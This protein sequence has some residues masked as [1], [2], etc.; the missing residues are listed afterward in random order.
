[1][2][3]AYVL[4]VS[5]HAI[6]LIL[7]ITLPILGV[8]LAVGLAVSIFQAAT[9]IQEQTLTFVPKLIVTFLAIVALM[10]WIMHLLTTYT[11]ELYSQWPLLLQ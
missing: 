1:M 5:R 2:T 3:D 10:P 11:I 6:W 9:Q 4:G 7:L 8:G